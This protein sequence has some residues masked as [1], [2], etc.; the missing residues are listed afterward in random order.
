MKFV[1]CSEIK[2]DQAVIEIESKGRIWD[3]HNAS[4][5]ESFDFLI[6]ERLFNLN[7]KYYINYETA[8]TV[9]CKIV[10]S[11]VHSLQVSPRDDEMP[12]TEDDCLNSFI[13]NYLDNM[14]R[15]EF[16]GGMII[17]VSCEE[18]RFEAS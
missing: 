10:L 18:F 8:E 5:F 1:G 17:L 14:V 4:E 11:G 15:F 16:W 2:H 7:F 12:F 9:N 3:L 13:V 6:A